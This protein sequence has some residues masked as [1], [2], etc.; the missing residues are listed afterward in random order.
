[1]RR[2]SAFAIGI[3]VG[4]LI[5]STAVPA[6]AATRVRF[7]EGRHPRAN[8]SRSA[9]PGMTQDDSSGTWKYKSRSP[10]R[11]RRRPNGGS[12]GASHHRRGLRVPVTNGAF[13]Y[14]DVGD[15]MAAHFEGRLGPLRGDGTASIAVPLLT[16]DEQAQTC[17]TGD[18][19]WEVEFVRIITRPTLAAPESRVVRAA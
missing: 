17:M 13:S 6:Y 11:T 14:D 7:T 5:L 19:T 4:T 10:A 1:M 16:A 3:V 12:A 18:L 2:R 9:W 8:G 15:S